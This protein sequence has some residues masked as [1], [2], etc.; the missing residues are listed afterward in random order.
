MKNNHEQAT[1]LRFFKSSVLMVEEFYFPDVPQPHFTQVFVHL[2]G[3]K[4]RSARL[5]G[6][7]ASIVFFIVK[8]NWIFA[9]Q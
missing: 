6:A 7:A 9:S 5:V 4:G 3:W 8:V 1:T 2:D